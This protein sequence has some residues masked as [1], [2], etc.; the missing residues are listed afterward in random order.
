MNEVEKLL[1]EMDELDT[2][3]TVTLADL[4]DRSRKWLDLLGA[5][6]L[7]WLDSLAADITPSGKLRSLM[8]WLSGLGDFGIE[9]VTRW[10]TD[11]LGAA[12]QKLVKYFSLLIGKPFTAGANLTRLEKQLELQ[13]T[14]IVGAQ[15]GL[16]VRESLTTQLGNAVLARLD[17]TGL[18]GIGTDI[19]GKDSPA[20][21]QI[22][23]TIEETLLVYVRAWTDTAATGLKLTYWYFMGT[24]IAT[25]RDFCRQ[26]LGRTF[27]KAEVESW[28]DLTWSGKMVGTT[29]ETIFWYLGGY[30]CRH[31]LLPVTKRV[32]DFLNDKQKSNA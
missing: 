5:D 8:N 9:G 11:T 4:Y 30:R 15:I 25:T 10:L 18:R 14:G 3:I 29:K 24:Q 2:W 13:V 32:Y 26:R 16:H 7:G 17:V 19:L 22:T 12:T 6:L 1:A 23:N 28:A 21:R 31:R 27:P 20:F